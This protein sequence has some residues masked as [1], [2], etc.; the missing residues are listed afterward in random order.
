MSN[1]HERVRG[2]DRVPIGCS[3]NTVRCIGAVTVSTVL[4]LLT[5]IMYCIHTRVIY[6]NHV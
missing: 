5:L 4:L 6:R 3:L 1:R 2:G